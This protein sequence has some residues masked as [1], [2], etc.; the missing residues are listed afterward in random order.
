MTVTNELVNELRSLLVDD[1]KESGDISLFTD[2]WIA[3]VA[4]Q[5]ESINHALYILYT[6]KAGK[7][8]TE[9]GRIKAIKAGSEEV[10][11]LSC[12][13]MSKASLEMAEN[14]RRLWLEEK[15]TRRSSSQ[16]I[17]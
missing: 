2:S 8:L 10:Q 6:Q 13:Q 15:E 9:E 5:A 7:M 1:I 17:Y 14:Y 12:I 4:G 3:R 16:F 11:K